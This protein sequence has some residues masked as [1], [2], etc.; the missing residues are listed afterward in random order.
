MMPRCLPLVALTMLVACKLSQPT[1]TPL[2]DGGVSD[3]GPGI[4]DAVGSVGD[5]GAACATADQCRSG[6]C[7]GD[8]C[9]APSCSDNVKNGT[10]AAVD[11]GGDCGTKCADDSPCLIADDCTSGVCTGNVCRG[12]ACNDR[13]LNGSETDVDCGG[14]CPTAC[15]DDRRC[16]AA[17]DCTS[18]VCTGNVC[19]AATCSDRTRNGSE[20]DVDCG[21]GC[22]TKCADNLRCQIAG[23]CSSQVCTGN[24]CQIP[25][26]SDQVKN[27]TETDQ[28]CG[29]ACATKCEL[30]RACNTGGDCASGTCSG[31]VCVPASSCAQNAKWQRVDCA[32]SSWVWTSNRSFSTLATAN[33][34]RTLETGCQHASIPNTCSTDGAG[35]VSTQVFTMV[36]CNTSWRHITPN[37]MAPFDCGG[38]DGDQ[39]RHLSRDD[40]S[41]YDY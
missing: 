20:T 2:D 13:V 37:D 3:T 17:V 27:G 12:A 23:D 18:G 16:G 7:T 41:C 11:C 4:D 38:H 10:E 36:G 39:Y 32:T 30:A 33:A 25:T 31:N 8:R 1:F 24:V 9:A 34:E 40:N 5:D 35:W 29:G 26:C 6:V 19:Q 14:G 15:A 22:G 28:D 21:G